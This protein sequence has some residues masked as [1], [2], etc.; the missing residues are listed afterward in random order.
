MLQMSCTT[1]L[2][3]LID[4][5]EADRKLLKIIEGRTTTLWRPAI[6]ISAFLQGFSFLEVVGFF[7]ERRTK[8]D[9]PSFFLRS[10]EQVLRVFFFIFGKVHFIDH[11]YSNVAHCSHCWSLSAYNTPFSRIFVFVV[12]GE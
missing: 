7:L 10:V 3:N 5:T 4:L 8:S 9:V 6:A 1:G 12:G 11:P 2:P